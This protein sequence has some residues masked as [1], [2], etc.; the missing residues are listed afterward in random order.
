MEVNASWYF[1]KCVKQR[2]FKT[3]ILREKS[4]GITALL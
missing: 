3:L 2:A 4:Y 1:P